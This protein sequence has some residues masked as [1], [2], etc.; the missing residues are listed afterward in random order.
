MDDEVFERL[1]RCWPRVPTLVGAGFSSSWLAKT[2][3]RMNVLQRWPPVPRLALASS[4][5]VL[6]FLEHEPYERL[7]KMAQQARG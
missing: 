6:V 2:T 1:T 3:R 5:S 4:W 7:T